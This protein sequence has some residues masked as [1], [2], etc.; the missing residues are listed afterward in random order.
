MTGI[1]PFDALVHFEWKFTR[2]DLKE[3][4]ANLKSKPSPALAA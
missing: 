4:I 1:A 3:L 2:V